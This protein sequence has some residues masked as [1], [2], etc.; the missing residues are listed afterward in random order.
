MS[1]FFLVHGFLV[2]IVID[3]VAIVVVHRYFKRRAFLFHLEDQELDIESR[4][5]ASFSQELLRRL[6]ANKKLNKEMPER[7]NWKKEGF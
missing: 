1:N 6:E 3:I 5:W 4:R 2:F 7:Q